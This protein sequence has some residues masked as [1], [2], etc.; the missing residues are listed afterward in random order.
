MKIDIHSHDFRVMPDQIKVISLQ[1][2]PKTDLLAQ[3]DSVAPEHIVSA[4]IHPWNASEWV[5]AN[6]PMPL[7]YLKSSRVAFFG[8]IGLDNSCGVDIDDQRFVFEQQLMLANEIGKVVLIH[9][10]GHQAELF[11]LKRKYDR[12]PAWILHGYRGK[13]QGVE[14]YVKNGFH[15]SFGANHH[16]DAIR[17]CPLD[18][19]FLESDESIIKLE[20]LYITVSKEL[21]LTTQQL[22]NQL[23]A[24]F[25]TI[26]TK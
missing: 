8:E 1:F 16:P 18:R 2:R 23:T 6:N 12:I 22:E 20:N 15:I 11:A 14:Q 13:W 25:N 19:L 17:S 4:G 7:R 9:N 10:V 5:S 26:F 3:L 21:G 24:N